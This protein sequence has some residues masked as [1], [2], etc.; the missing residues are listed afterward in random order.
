MDI[1]NNWSHWK[2]RSQNCKKNASK[3]KAW[4]L[5]WE[6]LR[7]S[8]PSTIKKSRMPKL[9]EIKS[10][11]KWKTSKPSIIKN[12]TSGKIKKIY[13]D[14]LNTSKKKLITRESANN[15]MKEEKRKRRK[16][17]LK[18]KN[19]SKKDK[20]KDKKESN[21]KRKE[22]NAT[23]KENLNSKPKDKPLSTETPTGNP[24]NCANSWSSTAKISDPMP[25]TT[26][27]LNKKRKEMLKISIWPK[28][29]GGKKKRRVDV[30]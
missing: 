8:R 22:K 28:R 13:W 16:D 17:K 25:I 18:K 20:K 11:K 21:R 10:I 26:R 2:I 3:N 14:T 9:K 19:N 6:T 29:R 15:K 7:T 23:S 12:W 27:L 5:R 24:S 4:S 1:I 30:R